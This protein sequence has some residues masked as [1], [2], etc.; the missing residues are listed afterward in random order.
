M[1][2]LAPPFQS[3]V[4]RPEMSLGWPG[5]FEASQGRFYRMSIPLEVYHLI[6]LFGI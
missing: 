3:L 6:T 1:N 2:P 4:N 5:I